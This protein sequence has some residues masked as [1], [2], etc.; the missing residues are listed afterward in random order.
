MIPIVKYAILKM[1]ALNVKIQ[2]STTVKITH[3]NKIANQKNTTILK[4]QNAFL[5]ALLVTKKTQ[6]TEYVNT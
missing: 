4:L 3:V 1:N 5:N 6:Y 2:W